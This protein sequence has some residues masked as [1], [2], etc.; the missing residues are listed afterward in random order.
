MDALRW[1]TE[2]RVAWSHLAVRN[3]GGTGMVQVTK[4]LR[5]TFTQEV[6]VK[7]PTTEE[8]LKALC[9][10]YKT[11][12]GI[13]FVESNW[14][15]T[16]IR[17]VAGDEEA[18]RGNVAILQKIEDDV[19]RAKE[20]YWLCVM[21]SSG[22]TVRALVEELAKQVE[23]WKEQAEGLSEDHARLVERVRKLE[24]LVH[25]MRA[26]ATCVDDGEDDEK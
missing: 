14:C 23:F 16:H 2:S 26:E 11:T 22:P 19:T 25:A 4:N 7:F 3:G 21:G 9:D 6:E 8:Q 18:I 13:E 15:H 17:L 12:C 20:S 10:K 5:Q 1:A 24:D